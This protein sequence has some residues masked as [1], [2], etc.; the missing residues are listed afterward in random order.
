MATT[1][2]EQIKVGAVFEKEII[3]PKWFVHNGRKHAVEEITYTWKT[4]EGDAQL[5]HFSVT[6]GGT[7]FEISYNQKTLTWLLEKVE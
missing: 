3:R 6:E 2:N 1:I 4:C 5:I 7:L